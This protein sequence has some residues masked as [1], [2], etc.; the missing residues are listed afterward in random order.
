MQGEVKVDSMGRYNG[1]GTEA[2]WGVLARRLQGS[3]VEDGDVV[4]NEVFHHLDLVLPFAI[5]LE[6][7]GCKEQR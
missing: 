2:K 3:Y 4:V 7:A 6:K 1:G 5:G